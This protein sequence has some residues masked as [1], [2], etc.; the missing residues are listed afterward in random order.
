MKQV[1]AQ[2]EK[3]KTRLQVAESRAAKMSTL[4]PSFLLLT[5]SL[6]SLSPSLFLTMN[7]LSTGRKKTRRSKRFVLLFASLNPRPVDN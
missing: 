5:L 7:I 4:H 6:S 2:L 1:K 3:H